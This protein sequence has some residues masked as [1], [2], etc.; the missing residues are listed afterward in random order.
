MLREKGFD[1]WLIKFDGVDKNGD[2]NFRDGKQYT[3]I[4]YA[5]YLMA[6]D[7]GIDMNECRLL[8]KDGL[9]H[10]MTKRFD[11][12]GGSKLHMVTLAGLAHLDYNTPC[13]CS[14]EMY[15]EY[16][17]K[18]GV[19]Q[20]EIEE[21]IR[22]WNS[23]VT[24]DDS[25]YILGD[26]A[27]K[28]IEGLEVLS[29]LVGKKYFILGNHDKLTNEMRAYFGRIKD[30]ATVEDNGIQVVLCHYPIAHWR[31][32]YR[33]AVH[34]YGHV[35]NTKTDESIPKRMKSEEFVTVDVISCAAPNLR[36]EPANKHNPE[37]GKPIR[38]EPQKLYD[39]HLSRAKHILHIAAVNGAE[40][41]VLGAFG[42]GAFQN[43]PNTVAKAYRDALKEYAKRFDVIEFA[44]YCR[45]YE[46]E[47][48]DEF[49]KVLK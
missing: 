3:N 44:I 49:K 7:A 37:T 30:I 8:Q 17:R 33:G 18:I 22:R 38:I 42:C 48:Y 40:I 10:F 29:Q 27:W 5:Y 34:L 43:D 2:H 39:L 4:E 46:S 23:V 20:K 12:H 45:D 35:H 28:N 11:R 6:K 41:I 16:A 36:N 1:H 47:N 24:P 25:V 13:S 19:T 21:L 15:A 32:Q 14:Y 9:C 31:N 26:F